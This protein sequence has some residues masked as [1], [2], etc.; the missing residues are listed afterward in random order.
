MESSDLEALL[1]GRARGRVQSLRAE[2]D[3]ADSGVRSS[4]E[5]LA[6]SAPRSFI[7]S[8]FVHQARHGQ[9]GASAGEQQREGAEQDVI[10]RA[11]SHPEVP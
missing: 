6:T 9:V 1:S 3:H 5:T 11:F 10:S 8:G 2:A 7:V 4:C